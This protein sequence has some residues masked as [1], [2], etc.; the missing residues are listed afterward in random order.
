MLK[1]AI[2]VGAEIVYCDHK[3]NS[4]EIAHDEIL[5]GK[6]LGKMQVLECRYNVVTCELPK[7][8]KFILNKFAFERKDIFYISFNWKDCVPLISFGT[9][10]L[11]AFFSLYVAFVYNTKKLLGIFSSTHAIRCGKMTGCIRMI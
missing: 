8:Y 2:V 10:D 3:C 5:V 9:R 6:M 1:A 7:L 11:A 4:V